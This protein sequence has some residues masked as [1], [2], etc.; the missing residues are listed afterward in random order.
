V[1]GLVRG[2]HSGREDLLNA[3]FRPDFVLRSHRLSVGVNDRQSLITS[4]L[5]AG[6]SNKSG[7]AFNCSSIL[8]FDLQ[9][10]LCEVLFSF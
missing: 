7:V 10:P 2:F 3:T 5:I 1:L 6:L 8:L 9:V 4:V